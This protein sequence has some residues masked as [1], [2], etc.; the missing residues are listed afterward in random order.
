MFSVTFLL[1]FLSASL[2]V[3]SFGLQPSH[4]ILSNGLINYSP[5]DGM[6][7]GVN[8]L[9]SGYAYTM[10]ESVLH[11]DF[12]LFEENNVDL[13]YVNQNWIH[14]ETSIG[15]YSSPYLTRIRRVCEI[16]GQYDIEVGIAF[17]TNCRYPSTLTIPSWVENYSPYKRSFE[18]VLRNLTVRQAW[19]NML[20]HVASY[21]GDL[22]NIHS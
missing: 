21:L 14:I 16:A 2:V 6:R 13:I 12:Q 1:V 15:S 3:E 17:M 5:V 18:T 10:S 9:S 22:T 8:Y 20:E 4:V 19:I 7:C 11:R